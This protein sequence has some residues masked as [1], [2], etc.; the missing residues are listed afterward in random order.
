MTYGHISEKFAVKLPLANFT[1][2]KNSVG[3]QEDNFKTFLS[4]TNSI[5]L[6]ILHYNPRNSEGL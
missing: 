2:K 6:S 5:F 4:D 1:E 3:G